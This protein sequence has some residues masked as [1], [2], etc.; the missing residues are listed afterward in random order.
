[1]KVSITTVAAT[2]STPAVT[3]TV[4]ALLYAFPKKGNA[5]TD[6]T[7]TLNGEATKVA[8]TGGGK[9]PQYVYLMI[10]GVSHYLPKN[11]VPVSGT[12]VTIVAEAPKAVVAKEE[13]AAIVGSDVVDAAE[14]LAANPNLV[15]QLKVTTQKPKRSKK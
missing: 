9:Y 11:V 3:A 13:L 6:Y 14:L 1:M 2:D 5:P 12:D 7:L 4:S 15:E 10:N 8:M